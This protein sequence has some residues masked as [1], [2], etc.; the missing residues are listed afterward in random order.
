[1]YIFLNKDKQYL[2]KLIFSGIIK[3]IIKSKVIYVRVI[4]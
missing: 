2:E 3:L 1:M 4:I